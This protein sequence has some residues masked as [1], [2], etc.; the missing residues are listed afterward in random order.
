MT[1]EDRTTHCIQ[2][3]P[4][5]PNRILDIDWRSG[6]DAAW[7][8]LIRRCGGYEKYKAFLA[9]VRDGKSR[10]FWP[11]TV[12]QATGPLRN[13]ASE[14]YGQQN[15]LDRCRLACLGIK[16]GH[17]GRGSGRAVFEHISQ[18]VGLLL[19]VHGSSD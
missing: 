11:L 18:Q 9:E 3:L 8:Q 14:V 19:N 5:Q 17:Q 7:D 1:T 13:G 15:G 2:F 6:N 10:G 12:L 16:P 4:G